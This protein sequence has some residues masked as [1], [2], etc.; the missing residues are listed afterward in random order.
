[1]AWLNRLAITAAP[2]LRRV[3]RFPGSR[4]YGSA[5]A[6][7]CDY[8]YYDDYYSEA[9]EDY[10][11]LNRLKPNL[12]SV[13]GSAFQEEECSG[14]KRWKGY[15]RKQQ[16]LL[17]F[18]VAGGSGETL[19]RLVGCITPQ[20]PECCF[21]SLFEHLCR[22][23]SLQKDYGALITLTPCRRNIELLEKCS[24]DQLQIQNY[25]T[26]HPYLSEKFIS[27][28]IVKPFFDF[29]LGFVGQVKTAPHQ[30]RLTSKL[31]NGFGNGSC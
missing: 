24:E 14:E 2:S 5:A 30:L 12:E 4:G 10:G 11:Q 21:P 8:D 25:S 16:K 28:G 22:S 29:Q 19:A 17:D 1:M 31:S 23:M 3:S 18:Q 13:A 27:D 26:V 6:V 20:T 7:Q 9:V 15:Y